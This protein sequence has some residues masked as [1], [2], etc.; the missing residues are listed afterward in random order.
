MTPYEAAQWFALIFGA[1][2]I[3]FFDWYTFKVLRKADRQIDKAEN[4]QDNINVRIDRIEGTIQQQV[5]KYDKIVNNELKYINTRIN[6]LSTDA[7]EA[8]SLSLEAFIQTKESIDE[9]VEQAKTY[10]DPAFLMEFIEATILK[11]LQSLGMSDLSGLGKKANLVENAR[12]GLQVVGNNIAK[13]AGLNELLEKAAP[14]A[15][16]MGG[17]GGLL[18]TFKDNPLFQLI[19]AWKS[20]Q[21]DGIM[22]GEVG[23]GTPQAAAAARPVNPSGMTKEL[24]K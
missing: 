14:L 5:V 11:S 1:V 4:T 18:E 6:K 8:L 10:M 12:Q 15:N 13:G 20:G 17:E 7:D 3:G 22:G 19:Y 2:S 21:F 23:G 16:A 9:T 24:K